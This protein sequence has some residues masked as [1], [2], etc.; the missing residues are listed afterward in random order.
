M[1]IK[2]N[3]VKP[4]ERVALPA[5]YF[6]VE[7]EYQK[8]GEVILGV[9]GYLKS[10]DGKILTTLNEADSQEREKTVFLGTLGAKG[11]QY[12]D[13]FREKTVYRSSL[14]AILNKESLNYIEKR[15]LSDVKR[16]VILNLELHVIF[17]VS[18]TLTSHLHLAEKVPLPNKEVYRVAFAYDPKYYSSY[19]NLWVLSAS[20][21]PGFLNVEKRVKTTLVAITET[22]W[23]YD[24]APK[25]GLGEYF[26]VEIPKG[27]NVIREA[28][29]YVEKAEEAFRRWDSKSVYANCREAGKLLNRV[30]KERF[31]E[32]SFVYKERWGRTYANFEKLASLDLHIEDIKRSQSYKAEEIKIGRADCEYLL[33]L[34]KLLI[35]FAEELLQE[36]ETTRT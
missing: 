24:F 2:V 14:M 15:R 8:F 5:L 22:D 28:W 17:L 29:S 23:I 13:A 10:D 21:G 32:E 1:E 30:I 34:T 11:S 18:A 4:H 27:G 9:S 36:Y 25:L 16:R 19:T 6:D 12:D 33:T 20:G 35:K 31:G 7:I 26:I 3:S